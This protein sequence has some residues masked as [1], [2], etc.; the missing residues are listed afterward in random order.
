MTNSS[1]CP[2]P[3]RVAPVRVSS[4]KSA[5]KMPAAISGLSVL[6]VFDGTNPRY[7]KAAQVSVAVW[8]TASWLNRS[9][10]S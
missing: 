7:R 9:L 3:P 1:Y 8:S 10:Y 4:T 2:T 6:V 5:M